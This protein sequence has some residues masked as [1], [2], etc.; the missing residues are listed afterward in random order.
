M[1]FDFAFITTYILIIKY[2]GAFWKAVRIELCIMKKGGNFSN[3][4]K[5]IL[6]NLEINYSYINLNK[7]LMCFIMNLLK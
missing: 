6:D 5:K 3:I 4:L 2:I 1:A 7:I